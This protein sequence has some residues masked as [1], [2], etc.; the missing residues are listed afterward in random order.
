LYGGVPPV[1]ESVALPVLPPKQVTFVLEMDKVAPL[2]IIL[3]ETEAVQPV[4]SVRVTVY[5]PE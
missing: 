2:T 5:N 3:A 4:R 1:N